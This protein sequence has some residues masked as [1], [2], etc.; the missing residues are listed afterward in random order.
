M[1]SLLLIN[2]N[3]IVSRLLQLSSQKNGFTLKEVQDIDIDS[4]KDQHYSIIFVDSDKYSDDLV[5]KLQNLSYSKLCYIST[6]SS[7]LP[8]GFDLLMEKPFLP[9]DFVELVEEVERS[10]KSQK[11]QE[12]KSVEDE[13]EVVLDL[14]GNLDEL[15]SDNQEK[16]EKLTDTILAQATTDAISTSSPEEL[17]DMVD[18]IEEMQSDEAANEDADIKQQKSAQKETQESK[19]DK[20]ELLDEIG[21]DGLDMELSEDEDKSTQNNNLPNEIENGNS[22]KEELNEEQISKIESQDLQEISEDKDIDQIDDIKSDTQ[23]IKEQSVEVKEVLEDSETFEKESDSTI[24]KEAIEV[25]G[26]QV[27]KD[28][29]LIKEDNIDKADIA[30]VATAAVAT[31]AGIAVASLNSDNKSVVDIEDEILTL[32]EQEIAKAV[33]ESDPADTK[34]SVQDDLLVNSELSKDDSIQTKEAIKEQ[35]QSAIVEAIDAEA[36]KKALLGMKINITITF[37]NN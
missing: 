2:D 32:D 35:I 20:E 12:E 4:L 30:S 11:S 7:N 8:E 9:T 28:S 34:E 14:E 13:E 17:A 15:D 6:K 16:E 33:G 31:G 27:G 19:S 26:N 18:E 5:I 22:E 1:P 37:E 23:D 21:E 3:K 36:I 29:E 25:A 24:D 10:E